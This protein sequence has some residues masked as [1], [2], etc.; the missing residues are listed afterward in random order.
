MIMKASLTEPSNSQVMDKRN[1]RQ[2]L[3]VCFRHG[4]TSVGVVAA[5][6]C[7]LVSSRQMV[8]WC[9]RVDNHAQASMIEKV[10]RELNRLIIRDE[11]E[12]TSET[13]ASFPSVAPASLS[14]RLNL[15][16]RVEENAMII[17]FLGGED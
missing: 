8:K 2:M 5:S 7:D 10:V 11:F 1:S 9:S 3:L 13:I 17:E 6:S 16:M 15:R 12:A 4:G 14:R